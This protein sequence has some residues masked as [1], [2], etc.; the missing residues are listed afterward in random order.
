[1]RPNRIL[2]LALLAAMAALV[3]GCVEELDTGSEPIVEESADTGLGLAAD[4]DP[5]VLEGDTLPPWDGEG[6]PPWAEED[7]GRLP[8]SI[9][10][11]TRG[12][13]DLTISATGPLK[14][15]T[16]VALTVEGVAREAI[17]SGEVVLTLPTRALMDH[18]LDTGVPNLPVKARW[19]LPAMAKGDTW[20]GSYTVPGEAAGYYSAM[21]NAYT[22]GPDG[23]LWLFDD[24]LGEAWM[25]VSETDGQLTRFFEDSIFPEGVHPAAG[26]AAGWPTGRARSPDYVGLHPDSVYLHVVYS[27]SE[28]EGFKNAVGT[29][30]EGR[31]WTERGDFENQACDRP[32]G[33][34]RVV[35]KITLSWQPASPRFFFTV[36]HEYG[37]ALHHK[38]LGGLW[39]PGDKAWDYWDW[40]CFSH[41]FYKVTNVRC[42]LQEGFAHYAGIIGSGGIYRDC[43]E[44]FGDSRKPAKD[45][46]EEWNCRQNT[47]PKPKVEGRIAALF[48]DLTDDTGEEGDYTEYP[49]RYV[50]EV[51]RTCRVKNRYQ[52]TPG[53]WKIP[54]TYVYIWW[55]RT[56]VS[57][58]VW[59]LEK[60]VTRQVHEEVFP[61]IRTPVAVSE[62]AT[63][64]P[65]WRAGHIRLTWLKNLN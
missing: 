9:V 21:A 8:D 47:G 13:I 61:Y 23:G 29:R 30:V 19:D 65:N 32:R 59:C 25:Y 43:F 4:G 56:N 17:D 55:K 6:P 40:T 11:P 5:P 7:P 39:W 31:W 38:A 57:N 49:G 51:F 22:H 24:V 48:L 62:R 15:N 33:R 60:E 54:A 12:R 16:G 63:E 58:I 18:P 50:A 52:I 1:M 64:P 35:D 36:A 26:P 27:V 44:H 20:S 53:F 41:H 46:R 2:P 45:R 34:D 28:A 10:H 14:P 3:S 37:H 42:A